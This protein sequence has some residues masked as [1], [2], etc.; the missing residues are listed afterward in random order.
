MDYIS[1]PKNIIYEFN[2]CYLRRCAIRH[3]FCLD[4]KEMTKEKVKTDEK[5]V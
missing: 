1:K 5:Y 4:T 3:F 2:I